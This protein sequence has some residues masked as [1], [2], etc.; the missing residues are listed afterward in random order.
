MRAVRPAWCASAVLL[1]LC[2]VLFAPAASAANPAAAVRA[3]ARSGTVADPGLEPADVAD[4][5]R[6]WATSRGRSGPA[7]ELRC[8]PFA[9]QVALCFSRVVDGGRRYWTAAE[10]VSVVAL[11]DA[12][13][14][15]AA[16]SIARL[17][18]VAV[19]G[20]TARYFLG[21]LGD[22]RDHAALLDPVAL[23]ARVGEGA[24]VAAPARGV[25]VAWVPGDA[26]LDK[27]VAVGVRRMYETLPDA[28][29]PLIYR[30]DGAVWRTWGEARAADQAP[31]GPSVPAP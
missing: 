10:G 7:A 28:V 12:A 2:A 8:R 31:S 13:R 11:E 20:F 17:E 29:S 15:A 22:G 26:E 1:A 23:A 25:L 6:A 27:V 5:Y 30:W 24:V 21:A 18:P 19:E 3:A 16:A 14:T 4:Q 9:E